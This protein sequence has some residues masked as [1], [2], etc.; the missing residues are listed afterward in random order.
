MRA[1]ASPVVLTVAMLFALACTEPGPTDST[2]S[3]PRPDDPAFSFVNGPAELPI[4]ARFEDNF[5][6]FF[7][8][9]EDHIVSLHSPNNGRRIDF[10]DCQS[11]SV[12][13][14]QDLQLVFA[15]SGAI[16]LLALAHN[17]FVS[18]HDWSGEPEIN[19]EF[20]NDP[21]RLLAT[22]QV[23]MIAYDNDVTGFDGQGTNSF[24]N[25]SS[26]RVDLVG[27]GSA[28]YKLKREHLIYRN[29]TLRFN[30]VRIGPLLR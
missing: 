1:L 26:G 2:G 21:T 9:F 22:G 14:P 28:T 15:P 7:V 13:N 19:C 20:V 18:V 11:V 6:F 23:Q 25:S 12:M 30:V 16:H 29:E 17:N 10:T 24:G 8:N 3:P 4:I 27:G 5:G